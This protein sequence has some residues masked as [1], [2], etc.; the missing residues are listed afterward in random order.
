MEEGGRGVEDTSASTPRTRALSLYAQ[1]AGK[2]TVVLQELLD[3]VLN[4]GGASR[5][6]AQISE[7]APNRR[8]S[9]PLLCDGTYDVRKNH[10][11]AA[12]PP[13][14]KAIECLSVVWEGKEAEYRHECCCPAP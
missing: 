2:L 14:L 5:Q 7:T 13:E 10:S 4:D 12:V 11:P 6:Q 3:E 8:K 9:P 1:S